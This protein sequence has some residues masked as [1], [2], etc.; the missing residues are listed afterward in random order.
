MAT[1]VS[2]LVR[3]PDIYQRPSILL[4]FSSDQKYRA[5]RDVVLTEKVTYTFRPLL[6]TFHHGRA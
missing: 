1:V 4:L 6:S 3:P 2:L 5:G